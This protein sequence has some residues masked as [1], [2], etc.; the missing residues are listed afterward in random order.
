[1][2]LIDELIMGE[3]KKLTMQN[4]VDMFCPK[5]SYMNIW[6]TQCVNFFAT[7]DKIKTFTDYIRY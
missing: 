2:N 1:M 6:L 3:A 5:N 7:C 4:V